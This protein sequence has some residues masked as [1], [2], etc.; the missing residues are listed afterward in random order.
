M[1]LSA[2]EAATRNLV[3]GA[4]TT[5]ILCCCRSRR[6][7]REGDEGRV[8]QGSPEEASP[9]ACPNLLILP[10]LRKEERGGLSICSAS[11]KQ[12]RD[13]VCFVGS[14]RC[15]KG[16]CF[17]GFWLP[18]MGGPGVGGG[19]APPPMGG[20]GMPPMPPFGMPPMGSY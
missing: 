19:F 5:T 7:E 20:M 18:G 10:R 12:E 4:A 3:A 8:G 13:L 6:K 2:T 15:E 17:P 9:A 11:A 1:I 16:I 14:T